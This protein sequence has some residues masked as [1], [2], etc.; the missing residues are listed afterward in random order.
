MYIG[1]VY[2]EIILAVFKW[3]NVS[4]LAAA[5]ADLCFIQGLMGVTDLLHECMYSHNTQQWTVIV[6]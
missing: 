6:K 1:S 4:V 2:N 5:L 3:S